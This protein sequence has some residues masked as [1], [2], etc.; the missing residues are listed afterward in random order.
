M[1]NCLGIAQAQASKPSQIDQNN[2]IKDAENQR[3]RTNESVGLISENASRG[4]KSSFTI[5][6]TGTQ[7]EVESQ[8]WHSW[9]WQNIATLL[10]AIVAIWTGFI[11]IRSL[12]EISQQ[13]A[14]AKVALTKLERP[15]LMAIPVRFEIYPPHASDNTPRTIKFTYSIQNVGRSPAWIIGGAG[16]AQIIA[17]DKLPEEPNYG[18][19][20]PVYS[21]TPAPPGEKG[22]EEYAELAFSW[23]EFKALREGRLNFVIFGFMKYLSALRDE[24]HVTRF[25][26]CLEKH[27]TSADLAM[28]FCGPAA[29]NRYA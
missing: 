18:N 3:E 21:Q 20:N 2:R 4:S 7:I 27:P 6:L 1:V 17:K 22:R 24:I 26:I 10:L 12:R 29:Y 5:V 8:S 13:A 19:L 25:C 14:I 28:S 15:W 9:F 16:K 23:E 11:A